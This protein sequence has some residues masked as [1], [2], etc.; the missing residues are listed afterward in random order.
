MGYRS[1]VRIRMRKGGYK[2]FKEYVD[3]ESKKHCEF[4]KSNKTYTDI[5]GVVRVS[6]DEEYDYNLLNELDICVET[7]TDMYIGWDYVKWYEN[8]YKDV[9][10]IMGGLDHIQE[11]GY[12]YSYARIGEDFGDI[13]E[14]YIEGN[15]I[16]NN[17]YLECV[18][19]IREFD[20]EV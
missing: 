16:K 19:I 15:D 5:N 11:L 3:T 6:D 12:S 1:S 8:G 9:D 4:I 18:S 2:D 13:D 7:E 14:V 17:E 20:D 10:I